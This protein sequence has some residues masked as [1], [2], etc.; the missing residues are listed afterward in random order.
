MSELIAESVIEING[1]HP[2][3]MQLYADGVLERALAEGNLKLG[4]SYTE[5]AWDAPEPDQFFHKLL[6]R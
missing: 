6:H 2:W 4:E 3:D 1:A 5:G